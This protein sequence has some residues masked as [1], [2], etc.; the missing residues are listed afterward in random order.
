M[1]R[2][3]NALRLAA[4]AA[5]LLFV[6]SCA[7]KSPVP[8]PKPDWYFHDLVGVDFVTQNIH[9]P[10]NPDVLLVD[11]RP[12]KPKHVDGYIPTSI[13]IPLRDFDDKVDL[14]PKNKDALIIYYCEGVT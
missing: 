8:D 9:M 10:H 1:K 4:L 5:L 3:S 14:L 11:A 13:N 2:Y 12:Y 7:A 6:A